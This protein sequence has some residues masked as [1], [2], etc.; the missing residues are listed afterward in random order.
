MLL[1]LLK[2]I[3]FCLVS[4]VLLVLIDM[5]IL[6]GKLKDILVKANT[7]D[8]SFF[9]TD[10]QSNYIFIMVTL[11]AISFTSYIILRFTRGKNENQKEK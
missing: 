9:S 3:R 6:G 11:L 10:G 4:M 8:Y 5:F 2:V 7:S 1:R